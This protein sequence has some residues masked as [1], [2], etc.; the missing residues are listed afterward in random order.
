MNTKYKI[1]LIVTFLLMLAM[2]A[3]VG[4]QFVMADKKINVTIETDADK[5]T[6]AVTAAPAIPTTTPSP[7]TPTATALPKQT[8]NTLNYLITKTSNPHNKIS[9]TVVPSSSSWSKNDQAKF[10]QSLH[11]KTRLA[12]SGT[13]SSSTGIGNELRGLMGSGIS[14]G[15]IRTKA[16]SNRELEAEKK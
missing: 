4:W 12:T 14:N 5:N 3:M 2:A 8:K 13:S 11:E 9:N 6:A 15:S 1:L 7:T 16:K 10:Y